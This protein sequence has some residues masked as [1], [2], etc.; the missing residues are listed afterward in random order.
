VLIRVAEPDQEP[1]P[2]RDSVTRFSTL[3]FLEQKPENFKIK[4]KL[5]SCP[6]PPGLGLKGCQ[7]CGIIATACKIN[8][9]T[10]KNL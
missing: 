8:N 1:E 2:I 5:V 3:Q 4:K 9:V 6:I 7:G 10:I